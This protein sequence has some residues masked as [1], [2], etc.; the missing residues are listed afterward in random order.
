MQTQNN[1]LFKTIEY[2]EKNIQR[3]LSIKSVSSVVGYSKWHLQKL[4]RKTLGIKIGAYIRSRRLSKAAILLKQSHIDML[5]IS[6]SLGF[7]SQQAFTR[8]F[9]N[10]F[11]K[12]PREFRKSKGWDFVKQLP[13]YSTQRKRLNYFQLTFPIDI[14][15]LKKYGSF[16]Y[17]STRLNIIDN[18]SISM[19]NNSLESQ[20][21]KA[22][23][24]FSRRFTHYTKNKSIKRKE[25][26]RPVYYYHIPEGKYVVIPF[27]GHLNEYI[28]FKKIMY[29]ELLPSINIQMRDDFFIELHGISTPNLEDDKARIDFCF[30]IT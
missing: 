26:P 16:F 28:K 30:P 1:I 23:C 9:K 22:R 12:T 17:Y 25:F 18:S 27:R 5:A 14:G 3:E 8:S 29:D 19:I 7:R 11:G 6:F 2:I 4:F 15:H 20:T 21:V 24:G 10:F 13:P